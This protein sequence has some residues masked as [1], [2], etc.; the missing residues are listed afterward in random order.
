MNWRKWVDRG[1]DRG[2]ERMA[3]VRPGIQVQP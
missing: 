3:A 1:M 2:M